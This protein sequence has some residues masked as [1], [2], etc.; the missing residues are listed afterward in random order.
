MTNAGKARS[1]KNAFRHGLSIPVS[2][3][4]TL[5]PKAEA[6]A[7]QIAGRWA[8]EERLEKARRF[9]S[10][11]VDIARVRAR[12]KELIEQPLLDPAYLSQSK[13]ELRIS[14]VIEERSKELARLD[15][16]ERRAIS[17][18]KNA[19]RDLDSD[20]VGHLVDFSVFS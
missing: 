18:R 7:R 9:G 6:I 15:R 12:R 2:Q 10:A 19:I 5:A 20:R 11:Q 1:S 14:E 4:P 13:V 3:D 16:Y 17:R 8:S